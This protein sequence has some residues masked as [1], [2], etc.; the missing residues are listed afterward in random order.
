MLWPENGRALGGVLSMLNVAKLLLHRTTV[1]RL[2]QYVVSAR[3]TIGSSSSRRY[4]LPHL[5]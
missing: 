4:Y 3:A 1:P 2:N 5:S